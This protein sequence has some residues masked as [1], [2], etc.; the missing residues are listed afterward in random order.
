[1]SEKVRRQ[2]AGAQDG[3]RIRGGRHTAN[4]A[5][6]LRC[7]NDAAQRTLPLAMA[8]TRRRVAER[9]SDPGCKVEKKPGKPG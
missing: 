5:Y 3:R 9:S 2:N 1:M 7:A 6:F 4:G 8:K